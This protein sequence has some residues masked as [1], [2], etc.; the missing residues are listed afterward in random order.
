MNNSAVKRILLLGRLLWGR[1]RNAD[2][3]IVMKRFLII[4]L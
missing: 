1:F 4:P 2:N 3:K